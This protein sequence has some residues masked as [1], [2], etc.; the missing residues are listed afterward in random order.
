M[1]THTHIPFAWSGAKFEGNWRRSLG[2]AVI[3]VDR[4]QHI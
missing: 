2:I 1:H 4:V 3:M